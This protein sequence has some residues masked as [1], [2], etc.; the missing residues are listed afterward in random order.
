MIVLAAGFWLAVKPPADYRQETAPHEGTF[1]DNSMVSG[2][3]GDNHGFRLAQIPGASGAIDPSVLNATAI[4]AR[5][6]EQYTNRDSETPE[7][8]LTVNFG[9]PMD[10]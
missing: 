2:A 4:A 9:I 1:F 3:V 5:R 7:T 8:N 6:A 10:S